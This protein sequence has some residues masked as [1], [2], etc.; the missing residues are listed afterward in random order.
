MQVTLNVGSFNDGGDL[1]RAHRIEWQLR[2]VK[3]QLASLLNVLVADDGLDSCVR[4][5]NQ[6]LV[7]RL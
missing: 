1:V 5:V 7:N 2:G 3:Y 4:V 6:Q